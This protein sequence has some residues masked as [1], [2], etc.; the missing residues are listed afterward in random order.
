MYG[1][2]TR[3]IREQLAILLRQHRIQHR[4]GGPGIPTLPVTT[5]PAERRLLGLQLGRY[6]HAVLVWALEAVRAVDPS[7]HVPLADRRDRT[8]ATEL[9]MRLE[10]SVRLSMRRPSIEELNS[11]QRYPMLAAWQAAARAASLGEHDFGAGISFSTLRGDQVRTVLK[12]AATVTRA[13]VVLDQRYASIPGWRQLGHAVR[14]E[15]AADRCIEFAESRGTDHSVDLRGWRPKLKLIEQP[16][17][18]G[19]AGV[20]HVH[21]NLL[22]TL[23]SI[24]DARDLR[25]IVASQLIT[26]RTLGDLSDQDSPSHG[27]WRQ[28]EAKYMLLQRWTRDL[29]GQVGHGARA[30]SWA[31]V[32][33]TRTKHLTAEDLHNEMKVEELHLLSKRIDGRISRIIEGAAQRRLF[34]ER[35]PLPGMDIRSPNLVKGQAA[36]YVPVRATASAGLVAFARTQ[37]RP[38]SWNPDSHPNPQNSRIQLEAALNCRFQHDTVTFLVP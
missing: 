33:A 30:A 11:P 36:E 12:D 22:V 14:V 28:R 25:R 32:A 29:Y 26:S 17:P 23:N 13:L 15:E 5:T 20:L 37:L 9:Q 1:E 35:V 3:I 10:E 18:S 27:A 21:H 8:P 2:N 38:P 4:I 34:Y 16:A 6:R 19:L 7:A 31:Y 24:P